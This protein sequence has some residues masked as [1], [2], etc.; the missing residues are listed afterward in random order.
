M[1]G[2]LWRALL[3]LCLLA[4]RPAA[5]DPARDSRAPDELA[6]G[7]LDTAGSLH[8]NANSGGS[9]FIRAFGQRHMAAPDASW[10]IVCYLCETLPSLKDGDARLVTQPDGSQGIDVTFTLM[11]GLS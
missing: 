7:L 3:L 11:P 6:L 4:I 10:H 5:A 8:P 2:A 1:R 9:S